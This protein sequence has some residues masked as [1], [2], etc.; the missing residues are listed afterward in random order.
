MTY[1]TFKFLVRPV[2]I[3][4]ENGQPVGEAVLGDE[5][6]TCFG[7]QGLTSFADGWEEALRQMEEQRHVVPD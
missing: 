3:E 4:R 5:P 2:V 7:V 6:F 1:E